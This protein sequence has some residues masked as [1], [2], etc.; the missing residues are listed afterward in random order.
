MTHG[1]RIGLRPARRHISTQQFRRIIRF[2][3]SL[4]I[5]LLIAGGTALFNWLKQRGEKAE[6]WAN[7]E[8]P[9][10][11]RRRDTNQERHPAPP[12]SQPPKKST[13]W[14]EELRKM[15][16]GTVPST[17]T[18]APQQPPPIVVQERRPPPIPQPPPLA[19]TRHVPPA[20]TKTSEPRFYKGHCNHCGEHIEFP[21]SAME[22]VVA[23]PHCHR[24]TVLRPFEDTRVEALS[25]HK[26]LSSFVSSTRK[27]NATLNFSEK[28]SAH[29]H[30]AG[31]TPVESTSKITTRQLWPEVAETKALFKNAKTVR[32]AMI[33]SL[34]LG[35]PKALENQP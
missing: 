14:E 8:Q 16:E 34:I 31:Y 23:C 32:Q 25:H 26:D 6:D 17:R 29:M 11:P 13:D 15:L 20:R 21:P 18:P 10:P 5:F 33:A 24:P 9:P 7:T 3:E 2:M 1:K 35:Q 19:P 12:V 28:V 30:G 4:F 22:E 27:E